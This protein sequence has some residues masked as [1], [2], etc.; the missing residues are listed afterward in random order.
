[1]NECIVSAGFGSTFAQCG[2]LNCSDY[3]CYVI[4]KEPFVF[5]GSETTKKNMH[6]VLIIFEVGMLEEAPFRSRGW[7]LWTREQFVWTASEGNVGLNC[8]NILTFNGNLKKNPNLNLQALIF[9]VLQISEREP[10]RTVERSNCFVIRLQ[11]T[12]NVQ[13]K[14]A[15]WRFC[16]LMETS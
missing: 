3:F 4:K 13:T 7:T 10:E 6:N 1:M 16:C 5:F 2:S 11:M 12:R 9:Q 15:Q 8:M 14:L